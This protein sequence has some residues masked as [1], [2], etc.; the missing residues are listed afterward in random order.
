MPRPGAGA[1]A[2]R[3]HRGAGVPPCA[4]G[5]SPPRCERKAASSQL[6]P[7]NFGARR[8]PQSF[9]LATLP[10]G[11]RT[12]SALPT[13][14]PLGSG[15]VG[16]AVARWL[17]LRAR[18]CPRCPQRVCHPALPSPG[19]AR[20]AP[21]LLSVGFFCPVS[22]RELSRTPRRE[23]GRWH[24]ARARV[25]PSLG[26]AARGAGSCCG[27]SPRW[28]VEETELAR[29]WGPKDTA[30]ACG[31]VVWQRCGGLQSAAVPALGCAVGVHRAQLRVWMLLWARRCRGHKA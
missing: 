13:S 20:P 27:A 19:M 10:L 15:R 6:P 5:S 31:A 28:E 25:S 8:Q 3:R 17:R 2:R 29:S 11:A 23:A 22:A 1:H 12:T 9:L 26:R 21:R 24:A 14:P 7:A 18:P 16:E 4:P 30:E